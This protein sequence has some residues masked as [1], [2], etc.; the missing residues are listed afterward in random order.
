MI[1]KTRFFSSL[2]LA[3]SFLLIQVGGVF[4]APEKE[5]QNPISGV[6][7]RITLEAD[8]I[9]GVTIVLVDLVGDDDVV[10][11]V[12]V[13]LEAAIAQ[14]LVT[15]NG[16]G[17]PDINTSVLGKP[18]E[19]DPSALIPTQDE[20]EHP[21][22]GALATFFSEIDGL[23]YEAVMATREQGVGFGLIA[24]SLWLTTK[25][26]GDVEIFEALIR[27]KQT[28]DFSSFV[29]EN[30]SAPANWGQLRK[31]ILATDNKNGLGVI[32]SNSN[33]GNEGGNGQGNNG[34]G[35]GTGNGNNGNG[36]GNN[37]N[38]NGNGNNEGQGRGR[39]E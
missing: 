30:G 20:T 9:T 21:V 1:N 10:Q 12:R 16:D 14:G 25:L 35:N 5:T 17:K 23:T 28:G 31:A 32:R 3:I 36:N 33:P 13:S 6:I 38:G 26:E 24:Q 22:G 27:A 34:N 8:T 19:I 37:G 29:L 11:S 2:S 18:V 15:V 4:A 39:E 7:Q